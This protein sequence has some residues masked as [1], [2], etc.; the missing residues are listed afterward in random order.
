MERQN[1]LLQTRSQFV[2]STTS[3]SGGGGGDART[4]TPTPERGCPTRG[5]HADLGTKRAFVHHLLQVL[6][7]LSMQDLSAT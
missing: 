1:Y 4:S 2:M 3:S 7:R 6:Y 5:P